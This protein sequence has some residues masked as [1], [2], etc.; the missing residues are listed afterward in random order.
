MLS[1]HV[2]SV[3]YMLLIGILYSLD[4]VFMNQNHTCCFY[5]FFSL[6]SWIIGI[7]HFLLY[8]VTCFYTFSYRN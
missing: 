2:G 7:D 6:A 3:N 5:A 4:L 8:L 1:N